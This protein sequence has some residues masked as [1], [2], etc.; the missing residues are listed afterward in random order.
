[1]KR[2]L[3]LIAGLLALALSIRAGVAMEPGL[4]YF[5]D[6]GPAIDALAR[7]DLEEMFA[8]QP[9]MGTVSLIVRAPLV[10]AVFTSSETSV[11]LIGVLP[12]LIASVA[13]GLV[14]SRSL[15]D[16]G[17]SP[18]AQ[19]VVAGLAVIN[20]VTFRAVH[21]GH[22]EELLAAA[23]C[24]GAVLAALRERQLVA[25]L[26]LGLAVGTKQWAV[27]AV[28]PT[29]IATP[30]HRL[31]L[32]GTAGAVAAAFTLPAM[33]ADPASFEGVAKGVAAQGSTAA[34]TTPWNIWWPLTDLS[35]VEGR[36]LRYVLPANLASLTHPL[37][38]ALA[39]PLTL[40]LYRRTERRLDDALL[41]L[42][43]LLLLRCVLDHWN[44]DYY[45]YPFLLSLLAWESVR[46]TGVP[47]LTLSVTALLGLSFW[48][49]Q[50]QVFAGSLEHAQL[51]NALYLVWAVPLTIGLAT[52]LYAP[53]ALRKV[54][55]KARA[56]RIAR[57]WSYAAPF[58]SSRSSSD[59][60]P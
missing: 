28:L 52:E 18:A 55:L 5:S 51:L 47:V 26:L 19:G 60:R 41:L 6:A 2:V 32:A 10:A 45:H 21:W 9:L 38:V 57:Q 36:G 31:L 20:P 25:G 44:N 58:F 49:Q 22:P 33:L 37:I 34:Q 39:V 40:A 14:L 12:C 43:L 59:S 46:R 50:S 1:M 4:D 56:T 23:F 54:L 7:G 16:R 29:L 30:H 27:L 17:A 15:A 24:V 53:G 48:P 8:A 35:M 42:T 3:T 13:I 11:Y